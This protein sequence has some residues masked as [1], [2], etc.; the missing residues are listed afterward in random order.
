M[1]FPGS[2]CLCLENGGFPA[3]PY[4]PD[5]T[6]NV[7]CPPPYTEVVKREAFLLSCYNMEK[8]PQNIPAM[9]LQLFGE[10]HFSPTG[11]RLHQCIKLKVNPATG[12]W[13]LNTNHQEKK[14][15]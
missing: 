6:M 12:L 15:S 4:F 5:Q 1:C 11:M 10:G 13:Q 9:L 2:K 3:S 7:L 14:N 8:L